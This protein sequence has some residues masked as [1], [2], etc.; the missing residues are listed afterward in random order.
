MWT[1]CHNNAA[2]EAAKSAHVQDAAT[3]S[4]LQ[5][6]RRTLTEQIL[7]AKLVFQLQEQVLCSAT[8]NSKS[9]SMPARQEQSRCE[10]PACPPLLPASPFSVQGLGGVEVSCA[11]LG[12]RFCQV[13]REYCLEQSWCKT[14]SW[15]SLLELYLHFVRVTGWLSPVNVASW[16]PQQ[17]PLGLVADVP[18]CFVHETEYPQLKMCRPLL[19]KQL[20]V[21]GSIVRFMFKEAAI[22]F[23]MSRTKSLAHWGV[24]E[25]VPSICIAPCTVRADAGKLSDIFWAHR[26]YSRALAIPFQ[27][28]RDPVDCPTPF[29]SPKV[30]WA[31][32]YARRRLARNS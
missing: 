17:L 31:R 18:A 24:N 25:E 21:F 19:S 15:V 22:D 23:P 27:P 13:F 9:P 5:K 2:D 29:V 12:P 16:K 8:L 26:R 7:Q 3:L 1:A 6:A 4:L 20:N 14:E 10:V 28:P 30:T 32:Y 11:L